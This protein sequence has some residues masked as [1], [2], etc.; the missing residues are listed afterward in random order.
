MKLR[1]LLLAVCSGLALPAAH[2]LDARCPQLPEDPAAEVPV[3][4][5]WVLLDWPRLIDGCVPNLQHDRG[6]R[7]PL[8]IWDVRS[9]E[10]FTEKT[11]KVL[12]ERGIVAPVRLDLAAIPIAQQVQK[13]GAPVILLDA[14]NGSWPYDLVGDPAKWALTFGK[15]AQVNEAWRRVPVPGRL[16]GWEVA[17]QRLREILREFREAGVRVDAV[18]FDYE[19]A[20]ANIPFEAAKAS[21]E[22]GKEIPSS[23]L[24]NADAFDRYRRQLWIQLLS[25]YIAAPVREIYPGASVTN[26][27]AVLSSPEIPAPGWTNKPLPPTGPTLLSASNPVAYGVDSAFVALWDKD[28]PSDRRDIDRGY[29]HL[30]LRQVSADAANRRRVAP[31]VD[32]VV[33]VARDHRILTDRTVPTM[34]R[35]AYREA[36]RH[37]WLRGADAMQVYNGLRPGQSAIALAEVQD[38][39]TVYDELLKHRDFLDQGEAMNLDVPAPQHEGGIWSGLR[40]GDHAL[41]RAVSLT[42]ADATVE[43]GGWQGFSLPVTATPGG[44][45]YILRLNREA[46]RMEV[47][48]SDPQ[49]PPPAPPAPAAKDAP[50]DDK[51]DAPDKAQAAKPAETE[52]R[53]SAAPKKNG[54]ARPAAGEKATDKTE[55][56]DKT[57]KSEK[58]DKKEEG[59]PAEKK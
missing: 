51:T 9:G 54:E 25:S 46:G 16:E 35:A 41:V 6:K 59:R 5:P 38:A 2:G 42:G 17:A 20:P 26:W 18:W 49:V 48:S 12:L 58:S 39:A 50:A 53:P 10:P 13:A 22:A 36:L 55:K 28:L 31:Q 57:D 4:P 19:N 44:V 37:L 30:L 1:S 33:W 32:A 47:V 29:L 8:M 52:G 40:L 56:A 24:A 21:R 14:R 43:I 15:D 3:D 45:T 11:A 27:M 34:S 7:W 23:A